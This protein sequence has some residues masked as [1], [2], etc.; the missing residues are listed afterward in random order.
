MNKFKVGDTIIKVKAGNNKNTI[1][2]CLKVAYIHISDYEFHKTPNY[3][4]RS[5]SKEYTH[6]NYELVS[7]SSNNY[8]I[9]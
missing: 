7:N 2:K 6:D 3:D 9:Y 5:L 4:V 8:E 1:G